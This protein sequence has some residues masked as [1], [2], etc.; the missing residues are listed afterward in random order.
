MQA[1]ELRTPIKVK[2]YTETTD[3]DGYPVKGLTLVL[4]AWCRWKNVHGQEVYTAQQLGL[5]D[6]ATLMMRYS[7]LVT[8]TCVICRGDDV[9][10]IISIDNIEQR[11]AWLEIKVK[12]K[13]QAK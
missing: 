2:A 8:P 1:G 3:A 10:D 6:A 4:S 11:D 5:V 9:F 12:R 13:V 7:A